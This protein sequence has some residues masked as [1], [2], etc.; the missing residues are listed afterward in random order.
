V[1]SS[2][3]LAIRLRQQSSQPAEIAAALAEGPLIKTWAMRGTLHL[4]VAA[5]NLG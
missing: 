5:I 2:A 3:D 4:L 1:A